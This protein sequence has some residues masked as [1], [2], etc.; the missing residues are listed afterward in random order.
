[1][2]D[3]SLKVHVDEAAPVMA[4]NIP[5]CVGVCLC[6]SV[7]L[8]RTHAVTVHILLCVLLETSVAACFCVL[9]TNGTELLRCVGGVALV[10]VP[11]VASRVF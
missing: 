4:A 5:R 1:M 9:S 10:P 3:T 11:L 7:P 2:G 8:L 6:V